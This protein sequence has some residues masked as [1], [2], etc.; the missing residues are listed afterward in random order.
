MRKYQHFLLKGRYNKSLIPSEYIPYIRISSS[1]Y[2]FKC[3]SHVILM[4]VTLIP[5]FLKNKY[6]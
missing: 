6:C 4:V 5:C 2:K 1:I 3:L